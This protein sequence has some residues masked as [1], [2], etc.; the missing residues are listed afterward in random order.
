[1]KLE[2]IIKDSKEIFVEGHGVS[3]TV[4]T[5]SNLEGGNVMVH[6]EDCRLLMAGAFRWEELDILC[7]ALTIARSA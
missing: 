7:A 2:T 5:W 6:G 3:V 4:N 1:M